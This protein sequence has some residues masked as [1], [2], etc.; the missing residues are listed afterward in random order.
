[1]EYFLV[2]LLISTIHSFEYYDD[3]DIQDKSSFSHSGMYV[4]SLIVIHSILLSE[5]QLISKK[6][7]REEEKK[8]ILLLFKS[9]T[10]ED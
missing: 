2:F 10:S 5:I 8:N 4:W 6:L 3:D 9:I 7:R 1:M